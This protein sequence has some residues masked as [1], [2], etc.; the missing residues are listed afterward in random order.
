MTTDNTKITQ[1]PAPFRQPDSPR[2]EADEAIRFDQLSK[3]GN[4]RHLIQHFGNPE[5]TPVEANRRMVTSP[6]TDLAR[7]GQPDLLI[8]FDV[9]PAVYEANNGCVVSEQGN[10]PDFVIEIASESTAS[11]DAGA[12]RDYYADPGIPEYRRFDK[13]GEFYSASLA[14]DRLVDGASQPIPIGERDGSIVEGHSLALNLNLRWQNGSLGR[15]DPVTGQ[16]ILTFED[17]RR[18]ATGARARYEREVRLAAEA[19]IREPEPEL[20]RLPGNRP[21]PGGPPGIEDLTRPCCS[22]SRLTCRPNG[23]SSALGAGLATS[24]PET[25]QMSLFRTRKPQ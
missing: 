13:T 19:R 1:S 10:P 23:S 3:T 16:H 12:K 4:V 25:E 22:A 8:A 17:Q 21:G 6:S 15:Y 24:T 2:R 20:R 5:T 11:V 18:R 7:A 9:N 14:G